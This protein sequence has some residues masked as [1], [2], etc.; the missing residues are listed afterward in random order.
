[1]FSNC[2]VQLLMLMIQSHTNC[3]HK[4]SSN[5][6]AHITSSQKYLQTPLIFQH[7]NLLWFKYAIVL[8]TFH[9]HCRWISVL[10]RLPTRPVRPIRWTYS[11]IVPGRSKLI[12]CFTLQMSSPRAA[13][14][15]Q[16]IQESVF[17]VPLN[18]P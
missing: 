13:T 15:Q 14:L 6:S 11:S 5:H 2:Y 17:N 7:S 9:L 4:Q 16:H 12:T 8:L 10:P 1:M 3:Y 18:T